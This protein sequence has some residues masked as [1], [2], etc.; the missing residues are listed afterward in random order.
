MMDRKAACLRKKLLTKMP[1]TQE[2]LKGMKI[3]DLKILA[4]ALGIKT[5][6]KTKAK[7]IKG[8][9]EEQHELDLIDERVES[10]CEMC[11]NYVALRERAHIISEGDN[12]R[13][14]ILMLC[15]GCHRMFDTRVKPKL[16]QALMRKGVKHLPESWKKSSFD[17]AYEAA[18]ASGKRG[19]RKY[20]R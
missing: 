14:N 5:W 20:G 12:S 3:A 9:L 2:A 8:I 18:V 15:P 16:Y 10:F 4:S 19:K 11:G 17:Q 13:K 1:Y 6:Q 7:V